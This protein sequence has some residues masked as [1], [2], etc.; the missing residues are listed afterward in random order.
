MYNKLVVAAQSTAF[1][2]VTRLLCTYLRDHAPSHLKAGTQFPFTTVCIN[3]DY[4]AKRHR[5]K[6]NVGLTIV[7]A[8]GNFT[9]GKLKYWLKDPKNCEVEELEEKDAVVLN[10]H[11]RSVVMDSTLAHAVEPFEGTRFSLVYFSVTGYEK[12]SPEL[13]KDLTRCGVDVVEP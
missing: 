12:A 9:G 7:R 11:N 13:R 8:L 10:V 1:P 3:K 4:A 6:N 5:D 2:N